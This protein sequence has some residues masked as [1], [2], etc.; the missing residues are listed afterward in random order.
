MD[1]KGVVRKIYPNVKAA[2]HAE[3]VLEYVKENLAGKK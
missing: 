2:E 3:E 1:R